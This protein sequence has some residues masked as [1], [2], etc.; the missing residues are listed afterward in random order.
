MYRTFV[1]SLEF[2]VIMGQRPGNFVVSQTRILLK[3]LI[4]DTERVD[5]FSLT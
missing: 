3:I 5:C 2:R 1:C 4:F